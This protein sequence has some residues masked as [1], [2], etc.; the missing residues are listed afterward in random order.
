MSGKQIDELS[1]V[2]DEFWQLLKAAI[3]KWENDHD[4]AVFVVTLLEQCKREYTAVCMF[5][6]NV[7]GS[8]YQI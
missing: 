4:M 5:L 6:E 2:N 8:D 1:R 3:Y 7:K